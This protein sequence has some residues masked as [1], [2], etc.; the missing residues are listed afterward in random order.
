MSVASLPN[1]FTLASQATLAE[2]LTGFIHGMS[3]F[4]HN[5]Y[6]V[7]VIHL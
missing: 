4:S 6:V 3:N 7:I 1:Q 2:K 5:N